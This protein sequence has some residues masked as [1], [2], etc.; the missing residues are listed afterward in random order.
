MRLRTLIAASLMLVAPGLAARAADGLFDARIYVNNS[1]I[2]NFEIEQRIAFLAALNSPGDLEKQAVE[3]LIEDRLR[4]QAAQANEVEV[5]EE[6]LKTGMEEFAGR[7][8]LSLEQ[9]EAALAEAGVEREAFRDFVLAGM[10][11]REVLRKRFA[12]QGRVTDAEVDRALSVTSQRGGARVLLSE[13]I[14]PA[15]PGQ[16]AEA[17]SLAEEL[18]ATVRGAEQFAQAV[19]Q[20]SAAQSAQ[21]GGQVDWLDIGKLP[22]AIRDMLLMMNPG[23]VSQPVPIP[24]AVALFL[25]RGLEDTKAPMERAVNVDFVQVVLPDGPAAAQEILRLQVEADT[26]ADVLGLTRNLPAEQ[27]TREIMGAGQ[28]PRDIGLELAK[29][30]EGETSS[31]LRRGGNR[32]F[33]MLCSRTMAAEDLPGEGAGVGEAPTPDEG[34]EDRAAANRAAMRQQLANRRVGDLGEQYLQELRAAAI[35]REP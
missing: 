20:Y 3:G 12:S 30:D 23:E 24:N 2:T 31:A 22:P 32:Y 7:A 13:L 29:L 14:I 11:W 28:V 26:C 1:A 10:S 27:V 17:M 33:L 4:T 34:P 25:L 8:N 19:G 15:P 6:Q 9:F 35:I 16:E 18:S 5:T 21:Q